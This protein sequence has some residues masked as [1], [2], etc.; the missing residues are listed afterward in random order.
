M[1]FLVDNKL[2]K[3]LKLSK[4]DEEKLIIIKKYET[5]LTNLVIG[6]ITIYILYSVF[7]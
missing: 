4:S 2:Y 1:H 6:L 5:A 7:A 3:Y